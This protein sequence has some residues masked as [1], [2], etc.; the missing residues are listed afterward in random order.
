MTNETTGESFAHIVPQC[1]IAPGYRS[2]FARHR[3]RLRPLFDRLLLILIQAGIAGK[4]DSIK[5]F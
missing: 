1:L 4:L 3:W 5:N 2:Y